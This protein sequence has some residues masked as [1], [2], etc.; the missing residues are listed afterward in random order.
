M[1]EITGQGKFI[2]LKFVATILILSI[3]QRNFLHTSCA[4]ALGI[5]LFQESHKME[6]E[7]RI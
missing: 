3:L 1:T 5:Y 2:Y 6:T 4:L 7:K